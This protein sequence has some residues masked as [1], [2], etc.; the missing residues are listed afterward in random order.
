[1][2]NDKEAGER[3][4][5]R[6]RS[7]IKKRIR[8]ILA[9]AC[10]FMI[11]LFQQYLPI[12]TKS[13]LSGSMEPVF[14]TGSIIF[15]KPVNPNTVLLPGDIVTFKVENG[16]LITHRIIKVI[17]KKDEIFYRTKGDNNNGADIDLVASSQITGKYLGLTIPLLGYIQHFIYSK[18][19][20]LAFIILPG[21]MLLI[22]SWKLLFTQKAAIKHG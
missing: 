18:L 7:L 22:L 4:T 14:Y 20:I 21:L 5:R 17:E 15:E 11:G 1:M 10:M 13:I 16:V 2:K 19:G 6:F 3:M 8:I 12:Q 9:V